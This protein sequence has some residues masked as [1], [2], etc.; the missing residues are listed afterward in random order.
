MAAGLALTGCNVGSPGI[1]GQAQVEQPPSSR[2]IVYSQSYSG[3]SAY[4]QPYLLAVDQRAVCLARRRPGVVTRI[5]LAGGAPTTVYRPQRGT[6]MDQHA[7][8]LVAIS[9]LELES[10]LVGPDAPL[11]GGVRLE[12]PRVPKGFLSAPVSFRGRGILEASV[13]ALVDGDIGPLVLP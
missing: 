7:S 12:R 5:D 1:R 2:S 13:V 8:V 9:P 10:R 4:S 6:T 3:G 11:S